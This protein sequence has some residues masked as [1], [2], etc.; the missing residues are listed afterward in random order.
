MK[1]IAA[2]TLLLIGSLWAAPPA[3]GQSADSGAKFRVTEIRLAGATLLAEADWRP[4]VQ[5]LLGREIGFVEL[6]AVRQTIEARYHARGWR[7]ASVRIP[8]QSLTDGVVRMEAVEPALTDVAVRGETHRGLEHWRRALPALQEGAAPNLNA[9]D[10]QLSLANDNPSQRVQVAFAPGAEPNQLRAELQTDEAPVSGWTAFVDNTGN[11][12]TG[13]L[14]YGLAWRHGNL[15]GLGHQLNL[16][17]VSAPHDADNPGQLS[18]VPSNKV[19]IFGLGYRVPLHRQ[20]ALLDLTLGYSDVDSGTLQDLFRVTGQG[21]TAAIKYTTVLDRVD[22]WEPRWFI[23]ADWRRLDSQLL[24]NS[25]NLARPIE[26]HPLSVGLS[27]S[28]PGTPQRPRAVSAYATLVHNLPGGSDGS[29]A[30]F[31]AS[32]DGAKANFTLLRTGIQTTAPVADWQLRAALD[33]QWSNDLLVSAEQFS[34]GGSS[35]VRGFTD[36]GIAGDIGLRIQVEAESPNWLATDG[37][38]PHATLRGAVFI[39]AARTRRNRPA[40]LELAQASIAGIGIGFRATWRA[41]SWR[42]DVAKAVHQRTGAPPVWGAVHLSV[43]ANF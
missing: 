27:A 35:S 33:G 5:P 23:G 18:I 24:F 17:A 15:F 32:R 14:R 19:R 41:I 30:S 26:L 20:A 4:L 21:T 16:Q 8:A 42:L 12:Q 43:A 2:A 34:A 36:R 40:A 1:T 29:Q 10:R 28:R 39:D 7:L 25:V 38:P 22:G 31:S 6:E 3:M 9:L 13:R 11:S 37:P